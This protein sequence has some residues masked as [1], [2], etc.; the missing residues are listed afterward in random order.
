[1]TDI[2]D[3]IK[4]IIFDYGGTLDTGGCHWGKMIWHA[5]ERN[6]VH[7]SETVFRDAYVYAERELAKNPIIKP[8]YTFKKTLETKL[9]IELEHI[10]APS[11]PGRLRTSEGDQTSPPRE[12]DGERLSLL[13]DLYSRVEKITAESVRVL[14]ELKKHYP[15][16]LVSNFYGNINCVLTEFGFDG[17]FDNIIESAVV[18]VRKPDPRIFNLGVEALGLKPDEVLVVG[19]SYDKDIVAAKKAGCRTVW[20]RGEGWTDEEP[21]GAMADMTIDNLNQ[22]LIT[23]NTRI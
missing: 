7:V 8:D 5:Y 22:L 14:A 16:V 13:N 19:D 21:D 9:R 12:R 1:M 18:G 20:M 10:E 2:F 4:G 6:N 11:S 23:L 3:G 15:M 17:L